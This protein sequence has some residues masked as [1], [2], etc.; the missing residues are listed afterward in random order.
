MRSFFILISAWL[1][2]SSNSSGEGTMQL[3]FFMVNERVLLMKFPILEMSS[4]FIF[5]QKLSQSKLI[6][7]CVYGIMD[8]K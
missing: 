5:S 1:S 7:D 8:E 6:S 4:L 3:K 2:S